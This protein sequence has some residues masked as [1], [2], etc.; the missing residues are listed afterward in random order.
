MIGGD[1]AKQFDI[2]IRKKPS[3]RTKV[4][5]EEEAPEHVAQLPMKVSKGCILQPF[6]NLEL[7]VY[8][9]KTINH[10]VLFLESESISRYLSS[11]DQT[12][13]AKLKTSHN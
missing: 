8:R 1:P 12:W 6:P 4:S 10:H 13:A 7:N 2:L 3:T 11:C 5:S 9:G